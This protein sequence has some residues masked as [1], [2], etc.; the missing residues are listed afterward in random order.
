MMNNRNFDKLT[1][2]FAVLIMLLFIGFAYAGLIANNAGV[3]VTGNTSVEYLISDMKFFNNKMNI[4]YATGNIDTSGNISG[5]SITVGTLAGLIK[6]TAGVLSA[7]TNSSDLAG[8]ITDETG[9]GVLVFGTLPTIT[10]DGSNITAGTISDERLESQI[11]RTGFTGT[12]GQF[13]ILNSSGN[14]NITPSGTY[15][16]VTLI[17]TSHEYNRIRQYGPTYDA[18]FGIEN[19]TGSALW[20]W[21]S[22]GTASNTNFLL[23]DALGNIA[24][25]STQAG[26]IILN[27]VGSILLGGGVTD[28]VV[29]AN[30]SSAGNS[31]VC[32]D[33]AGTLYR[34]G[35]ACV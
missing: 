2:A 26:N 12:F 9:S 19:S 35:V 5:T 13:N 17:G 1:G 16:T 23:L 21:G 18:M 24:L 27:P 11:D 31:Y 33:S 14:M 10:L 20:Q 7:I 4:T 32:V 30:L 28:T 34:S 22:Y 8:V 3:T 15:Q 6:G 25:N 29:I